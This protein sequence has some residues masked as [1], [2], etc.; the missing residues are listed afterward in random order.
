MRAGNL[1]RLRQITRGSRHRGGKKVLILLYHQIAERHSDPWSLAV[2]PSHFAE[3]LEVL[4]ENAWPVRL[5]QLPE[6]LV[7]GNLGDRLV[8]I[9]F[10]D[11]YADNLHNA[12]PLLE[13]YDVPATVF[14]AT[15]YLGGGREFW[16]DELDRVLLQPGTLPEVL[17]LSIN[18]STYQ[19]KLGQ[20]AR[21]EE[22]ASRRFPYWR[23]SYSAYKSRHRVYR[24]L[25]E[26][27]HPLTE[28]E[29]QRVL[30]ELRTW[31]NAEPM[32]RPTHRPLSP[33]E[34]LALHQ[35]EMIEVGAHT[36]THPALS[37]LS[38]SSQQDEILKSK[39][40]L[41]KLL[42]R[43]V[44]GF[45]YPHGSFSA[46]TTGIVRE[47]GFTCACSSVAGIVDLSTDS[48]QLPRVPVQDWPRSKFARWL[49]RWFHS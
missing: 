45:S 46:E 37:T 31:A 19:W 10:D 38:V 28:G 33:E 2:T 48:F 9:T 43:A 3:H 39:A 24:S 35:R 21:Y 22:D 27:L 36:V 8:A 18:G 15:G 17:S 47:A 6:A 34:V 11:G 25:W 40:R 32:V 23:A 26:L 49:S 4:R 42:G 44:F 1:A 7:D 29:R 41:E 13:R 14:L 12:K 16:W 30:D 5:Q 20:A